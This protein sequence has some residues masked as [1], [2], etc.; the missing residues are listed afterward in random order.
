MSL[1]DLTHEQHKMAENHPIAKQL[2]TGTMPKSVYANFLF[3]NLLAYHAL[4]EVAK[5]F[6]LFDEFPELPRTQHMLY[7]LTFNVDGHVLA[8]VPHTIQYC[9]YVSQ[10]TDPK[11][12]MAHLYVR[13]MG[14]L[15][16]GQIIKHKVPGPGTMFYFENKQA[17]IIK[18]RT[19]I[20][21]DMAEEANLAF[22]LITTI[23]EDLRQFHINL[24]ELVTSDTSIPE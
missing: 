18:M 4:E 8:A 14:D 12:I 5:K 11:Q 21:D 19:L 15:F 6:D 23:M 13:H 16:G 24:D 7:D 9:N 1:R 2:V 20:N 10:L 17:L 22:S 3:N